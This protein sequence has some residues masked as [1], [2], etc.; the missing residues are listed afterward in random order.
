MCS[1]IPSS[2][3]VEGESCVPTPE[4]TLGLCGGGGLYGT[5]GGALE[6]LSGASCALAPLL[7]GKDC[8]EPSKSMLT[9]SGSMALEG[10]N[11]CEQVVEDILLWR[12]LFGTVVS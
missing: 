6:P 10:T 8:S 1:D 9:L 12:G 7:L 3:Y 4:S 2:S 5:S 11:P